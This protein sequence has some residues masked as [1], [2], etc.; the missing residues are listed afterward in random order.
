MRWDKMFGIWRPGLILFCALGVAAC[1]AGD[2][3]SAAP[4]PSVTITTAAPWSATTPTPAQTTVAAPAEA[5][6]LIGAWRSVKDPTEVRTFNADGT[7]TD[8][9]GN[10]TPWRARWDWVTPGSVPRIPAAVDRPV[11]RLIT[12]DEAGTPVS[13]PMFYYGVTFSDSDSLSLVYFDGI[14]PPLDFTRV[15]A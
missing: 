5:S 14:G 1:G 2:D 10:S 12:I 3:G 6:R 7:T 15:N 8:Q 4:S 9:A 13:A 11:L